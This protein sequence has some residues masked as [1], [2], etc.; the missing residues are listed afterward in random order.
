[1]IRAISGKDPVAGGEISARFL[2]KDD[3]ALGVGNLYNSFIDSSAKF[4]KTSLLTLF[5][6]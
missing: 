6:C 3:I 5:T 2:I 4:H 1:M